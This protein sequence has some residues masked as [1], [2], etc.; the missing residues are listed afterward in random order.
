REGLDAPQ[1]RGFGFSQNGATANLM[2]L[3]GNDDFT[4]ETPQQSAQL[5]Q[6]MFAFDTLLAPIVG[7]QITLSSD[8][9]EALARV[10]LFYQRAQ[11]QGLLPECDLVV[12]GVWGGVRRGAVMLDGGVFQSD[13]QSQSYT[14][15][16]LKDL[17]TDS[18]NHLTFMC[19]PPN[20]GVRIGVD[21]DLDG[22]F[23]GD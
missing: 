22:K 19:V 15:A 3:L 1:V 17:A 13:K 7:Q 9:S 16:Q 20:S 11:V 12:K 18:A 21:R 6:F 2:D 10:D 8:N 23:D 14:L 4:F 5:A